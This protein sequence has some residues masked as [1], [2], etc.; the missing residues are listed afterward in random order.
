MGC[1]RVTAPPK[2]YTETFEET[3]PYYLSI[4]MTSAEFWRGDCDLCK[5][6]RKAEELRISRVNR[7]A[8]LSGAYIYDAL[9]RV[10]PILR[11]FAEEGT[12]AEPYPSRPYP[13]TAA[14]VRERQEEE[15]LRRAA[16]FAA[17]ADE[18]NRKLK[19][20]E[21]GGADRGNRESGDHH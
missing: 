11:A 4:G 1:E 6:Y 2:S 18:Y 15:L 9:C 17:Y 5:A 8:W 3:F 20:L 7:E 16:E 10:S 14:E 21:K 12:A 19:L 13:I